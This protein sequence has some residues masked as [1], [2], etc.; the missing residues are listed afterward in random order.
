MRKKKKKN[1]VGLVI[2]ILCI[3]FLFFV[4]GFMVYRILDQKEEVAQ[5]KEYTVIVD[6][7]DYMVGKALNWLSDIDDMKFSYEEVKEV[8]SGLKIEI[9][10]SD[11]P[12]NG[13]MYV[14][15]DES[16]VA[17]EMVAYE[18]MAQYYK[19]I[20]RVNAGLE[21]CEE[22][23]LDQAIEEL[24]G[25]PLPEFLRGCDIGLMPSREEVL[26]MIPVY[27]NKGEMSNEK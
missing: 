19:G 7:S 2:S 3:N 20:F 6:P 26:K 1:P 14:V 23:E 24:L 10:Y 27:E 4:A 12:E 5:N 11:N 9:H 21:D 18:K 13:E 15:G 22:K 17:C 8:F 25:M 16:Y